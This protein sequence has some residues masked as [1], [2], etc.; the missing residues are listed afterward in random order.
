MKVF[1]GRQ[2]GNS[3]LMLGRDLD[4]CV[5]R[6][7]KS[8]KGALLEKRSDQD[9]INKVMADIRR[10]GEICN[11]AG[12]KDAEE[13]IASISIHTRWQTNELD[14]SCL[15]TELRHAMNAILQDLNKR[16][17]LEVGSALRG[18]IDNELL[19]GASVKKAFPDAAE[20]IREAGNCLAAD[21]NTAAVFHLM[22]VA[23]HGLRALAHDRRIK[24]AKGKPMDLAT[25]E[26]LLKALESAEDAIRNFPKTAAR[27]AQFEFFHGAMME[28][29]RFKNKFRNRVM[30]TRECYD[31]HEAKSAF[32]HVE[33]FMEILASRISENSRTPVI[34]K[35]PKWVKQ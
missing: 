24:L 12:L 31:A 19:F 35:G 27:E 23:E 3:M 33:E 8:E 13:Q 30:H 11:R 1:R 20:D 9:Q 4:T 29:K 25:W 14:Y 6:S 7:K 15:C 26:D 28:L 34:W 22:R 10:A 21:C 2:L 17:F 32:D 18:Y 5:I 16:I